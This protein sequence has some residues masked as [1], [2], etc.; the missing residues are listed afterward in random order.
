MGGCASTNTIVSKSDVQ[1]RKIKLSQQRLK[2]RDEIKKQADGK[3]NLYFGKEVND[4]VNFSEYV[5]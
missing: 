3:Q 2:Q 4:G 1:V 5:K